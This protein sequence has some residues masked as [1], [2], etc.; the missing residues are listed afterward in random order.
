[1]ERAWNTHE[2]KK[3]RR[4]EKISFAEIGG[5]WQIQPRHEYTEKTSAC[6]DDVRCAREC[7]IYD[8]GEMSE[9]GNE[10]ELWTRMMAC[11]RQRGNVGSYGLDNCIGKLTLVEDT[12]AKLVFE[13]P[14]DLPIVWIEMNY[15]DHI[16]EAAAQVLGSPRSIE[17]REEKAT[18]GTLLRIPLNQPCRGWKTWSGRKLQRNSPE[19]KHPENVPAALLS[20]AA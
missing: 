19:K 10:S 20:P 13:Y 18:L 7:P 4:K 11:M 6:R 17:L 1:M 2:R 9:K 5:A 14:Q 15:V 8:S 3:S 16:A 12:G